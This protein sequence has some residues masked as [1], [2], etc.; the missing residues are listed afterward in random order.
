MESF[1]EIASIALIVKYELNG[2]DKKASSLKN[3]FFG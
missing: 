1:I 2:R 3:F